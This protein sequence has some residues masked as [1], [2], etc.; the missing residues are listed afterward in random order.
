MKTA[1]LDS[2]DVGPYRLEEPIGRGGAGQIYAARERR[3]GKRVA[4]KLL[5][6]SGAEAPELRARFVREARALAQLDHP[7]VVHSFHA[8]Q[9]DD[10]TAYL[11]MELLE[12]ATLRTRLRAGPRLSAA[13][14]CAIAAQI[15]R[16]MAHVH[17]HGII[18]RDLKPENVMVVPEAGGSREAG[19]PETPGIKI[20][21]FGIAKMPPQT[22][23]LEHSSDTQLETRGAL[24]LGT[25]SYMAPEQYLQ[26]A[27]VSAR[28]DVYAL[29]VMLFEMLTGRPP[30]AAPETLELITAHLRD[31]APRLRA[32]APQVATELDLLVAAMLAKEPTQRPSM[33]RVAER[34]SQPGAR[35][36]G[37]EDDC[38]FPG[39]LAFREAQAELFFGREDEVSEIVA[40]LEGSRSTGPRCVLV[41]GPSGV[42]K[43]SLVHAGVLPRLREA[44]AG[45]EPRWRIARLRPTGDIVAPLLRALAPLAA[46]TADTAVTAVTAV[47]ADASMT[48]VAAALR[49][50]PAALPALARAHLPAGCHLLLVIDPVDELLTASAATTQPLSALL[51]ALLQ[52]D[53]GGISILGAAR[54]ELAR[55]APRAPAIDALLRTRARLT[56]QPLGESAL[57]DA[58]RSMCTRA[59]CIIQDGL[60][61]HLARD[62]LS[63]RDPL[64]LLAHTLRSLWP[65]P[66]ERTITHEHYDEL[67]GVAG[68]LAEQ[69][70]A[71][72]ERLGASG[73]ARAKWLLLSLVHVGRG[74]PDTRLPRALAHVLAAA[75]GDQQARETLERLAGN[76]DGP[77]AGVRLLSVEEG[78]LARVE[79]AHETLLHQVPTIAAWIE[80]ERAGLERHAD[81]ER[82]AET[83]ERSG[84][85]TRGLPEGVLLAHLVGDRG[86]VGARAIFDR[87]ADERTR[88]FVR[89]ARRH[90]RRRQWLRRLAV[91][92][93]L[94]ALAAVGWSALAAERARVRAEHNLQQLLLSTE[95]VVS[96]VDWQLSRLHHT[97]PMRRAML[98]HIDASLSALPSTERVRPEVRAAAI[99]TK[100]RLGDLHRHDGLLG[101]AADQYAAA[102]ALLEQAGER[103][104]GALAELRALNHSKQG[105]IALARGALAAAGTHFDAALDVLEERAD[106]ADADDRRTLA[107]SYAESAS[108]A[109]AEGQPARAIAWLDRAYALL[110]QNPG[111]YDH[112]LQAITLAQRGETHLALGE[113]ARAAADLERAFAVQAPVV[114]ADPGNAY[115]RWTLGRVRLAL[116]ALDAARGDSAAAAAHYRA[117]Y[118]LGRALHQ[119][120]REHKRYA[121]LVAESLRGYQQSAPA[122]APDAAVAAAADAL[123][124]A[125][126]CAI[127]A[128]EVARDPDDQRFQR[129]LCR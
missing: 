72:L 2:Q 70:E 106:R 108:L 111:A 83:W 6:A 84:R 76:G 121:L 29:G 51:S 68:A 97:L 26:P 114:A 4:L 53:A 15:A 57:A 102:G 124:V 58:I 7:D 20:I 62:A 123:P 30:F 104:R 107:T 74:V 14:A 85:P 99:Q 5:H 18:H 88:G 125:E 112:S 54:V 80:G 61:E 96:H 87:L 38:P 50:D 98:E 55:H 90:Q 12:G 119:G 39:L 46:D 101:D 79:L 65:Y 32:Y 40:L 103:G 59:G 64:P 66:D 31:P 109:V 93:L 25:V 42:G 127:A 82:A 17:E 1:R 41:E 118:Q 35:L 27:Q 13:E 117:A 100:H 43:S 10:G 33:R 91:A 9:L 129:L 11:A 126:R 92:A 122:P 47:T 94:A 36:S 105:K 3:S 48:A 89:S 75:G 28:V 71:V 16:A 77:A 8:D 73:R 115:F 45:G 60:A 56:L 21:D 37:A 63:T 34:L 44:D 113:L 19:G 110:A 128:R 67:G 120:D 49:A 69:A 22:A 52:G 116:G 78:E 86:A 95:Q 24:L 81:L 23:A